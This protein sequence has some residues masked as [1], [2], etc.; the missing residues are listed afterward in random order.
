[1]NYYKIYEQLVNKAQ[2][3][4][5]PAGT[6]VE[7]H[8][9][10]PKCL[11]GSNDK[12]N[13]VIFTG[14]Q[15]YI[16]HLLLLKHYDME[17]KQGKDK[18]PYYKMLYALSAMIQFPASKDENGIRKRFFTFRGRVFEFWKKKINEASSLLGKIRMQKL[19]ENK[20]EY[21]KRCQK[22]SNRVKQH[23]K[24][25]GGS[26]VGKK[27]S[28]ESKQKLSDTHQLL[29]YQAGEKNS[30]FGKMWIYNVETFESKSIF[31][32]DEIPNGWVKGRI[33]SSNNEELKL[34]S[35]LLKEIQQL[36]P[37][38]KCTIRMKS[39]KLQQILVLLKDPNI[40]QLKLQKEKQKLQVEEKCILKQ[41]MFE[42][43]LQLLKE[44]RKFYNTHT[45][46]EFL[47]KYQY[48]YSRSNF[49]QQCKKY[50]IK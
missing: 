33:C 18:T 49:I 19:K 23:C 30:Q 8:H 11:G 46:Q 32:T 3:Q 36:N 1:M 7:R 21:L 45:W 41:R 43:K 4:I 34:R 22:I 26:W 5:L 39:D 9:I 28:E 40:Q 31:K 29:H 20:D 37:N 38:I 42:Q 13:I 2:K 14:R 44:Q 24:I 50:N 17:A 48:K 27:H 16:A 35:Q 25:F 6:Y 15:H 47:D 12:S 10:I